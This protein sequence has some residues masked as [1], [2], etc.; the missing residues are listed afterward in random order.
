MI[1]ETVGSLLS[2]LNLIESVKEKKAMSLTEYSK[3]VNIVSKLY[4]EKNIASDDIALP[5][6]STLN[7]IYISYILTAINL[8]QL[9]THTRTV[10]DMIKTVATESYVDVE[11][12]V[13]GF[14]DNGTIGMEAKVIDLDSNVQ[15]LAAGRI[16]EVE[17]TI[18]TD[19]KPLKIQIYLNVQLLPSMIDSEV[20]RQIIAIIPPNDKRRWKQVR[21]GEIKFFQDYVLCLD[22]LRNQKKAL[23]KDNSGVLF[24]IL[25]NN[26][27]NLIKSIVGI[28]TGKERHNL[29]N[30]TLVINSKSFKKACDTLGV[31]F[32][33]FAERQRFFSKAGMMLLVVVD[34]MYNLVDIYYNGIKHKGSYDFNM[35]NKVGAKGADMDMK[36][37]MSV[38]ASGSA[39]VK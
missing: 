15:K 7:Q 21:A 8:N 33:N 18:P 30:S 11:Q 39:P 28:V 19:D 3:N 25:N 12:L 14:F 4:I 32:E 13:D 36:Q 9:V 29:Q 37:I 10:R 31:N 20:A 34:P 38:L 2:V 24:E 27:N 5:L 6:I 26:H 17:F 35:I 23:T 16:V 22:L 1:K